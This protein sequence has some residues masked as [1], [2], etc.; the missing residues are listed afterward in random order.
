MELNW[1][2]I[3]NLLN[4][5]SSLSP[6]S[7]YNFRVSHWESAELIMWA[8][9]KPGGIM[10]HLILRDLQGTSS[11]LFWGS[12]W[13]VIVHFWW[14]S[15]SRSDELDRV[16]FDELESLNSVCCLSHSPLT[17]AFSFCCLP[18]AS[19]SF[20]HVFLSFIFHL[21]VSHF[22]RYCFISTHSYGTFTRDAQS[23]TWLVLGGL[24][25]I[26]ISVSIKGPINSLLSFTNL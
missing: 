20:S 23:S 17:F 14:A 24:C 12:A 8:G 22:P 10:K 15:Q 2:E 11:V 3:L 7:Y 5:L 19:S 25:R 4:L 1:V 6:S 13:G 16:E 9:R 26:L 18:E 21:L